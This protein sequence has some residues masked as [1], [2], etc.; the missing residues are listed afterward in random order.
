[1]H[2][3]HT[4]GG[5]LLNHKKNEIWPFAAVWMY[6]EGIMLGEISIIRQKNEISII[7]Q[8]KTNTI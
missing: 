1:M 5:V 3:V 2:G 6:L 4:H 7:R 8:K